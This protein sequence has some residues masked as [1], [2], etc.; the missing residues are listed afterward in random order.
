MSDGGRDSGMGKNWTV[1][2]LSLLGTVCGNILLNLISSGIY[3]FAIPSLS[4]TPVPE[5]ALVYKQGDRSHWIHCGDD[6][7]LTTKPRHVLTWHI[8]NP[9]REALSFQSGER[10]VSIPIPP[11]LLERVADVRLEP[12]PRSP[13]ARVQD[14]WPVGAETIDIRGLA[15]LEPGQFIGLTVVLE[16]ADASVL[17]PES[18]AQWRLTLPNDQMRTRTDTSLARREPTQVGQPWGQFLAG[19]LLS[20]VIGFG[21][22]WWVWAPRAQGRRGPRGW[23]RRVRRW[24]D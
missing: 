8:E 22:A 1:V 16:D 12:S 17:T 2:A 21:A 19:T 20:Y 14:P 13:G 6:K 23:W 7:G 10:Q 24:L 5:L 18:L 9:G 4:W 15:R 11:D 3:D